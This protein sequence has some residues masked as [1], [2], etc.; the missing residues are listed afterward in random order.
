MIQF[1]GS[2]GA[3]SSS[4]TIP[5]GHQAGDILIIFAFRSGNTTPPTPAAGWTTISTSATQPGTTLAYKIAGSSSEVSGTWSTPTDMVCSVYRGTATNK[6]PFKNPQLN[7]NTSTSISYLAIS[8]MSCPGSSW[9]IGFGGVQASA[10]TTVET[11]P[12]GMTNRVDTVATNE[13][14]AHDTNG[15]IGRWPTTSVAL[16]AS[17]VY[18]SGTLELLAEFPNVNNY[19]FVKVA[20][21]ISTSEKIR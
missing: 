3:E 5:S 12:T 20:D 13:I 9:I 2:Q 17:V 21:G 11:P 10:T 19:Q 14:V 1:I 16:G 6:A 18:T 8:P 7:D 4:V 15:G